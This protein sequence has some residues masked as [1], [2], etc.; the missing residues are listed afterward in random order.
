MFNSRSELNGQMGSGI[1]DC[2][3]V[4]NCVTELVYST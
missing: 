4:A 2:N 3:E 1:I